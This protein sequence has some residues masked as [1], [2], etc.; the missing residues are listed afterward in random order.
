MDALRLPVLHVSTPI[1]DALAAMRE[2]GRSGVVAE[3]DNHDYW[4]VKAAAMIVA[5]NYGAQ[6]LGQV[7][8]RRPIR[9]LTLDRA[10]TYGLDLVHLQHTWMDYERLLDAE[11]VDYLCLAVVTESV[12]RGPGLGDVEERPARRRPRRRRRPKLVHGTFAT[13]VT[14]HED[15]TAELSSPG[16]CYCTGP[17]QHSFPPPGVAEGEPCPTGDG[18]KIVCE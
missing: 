7:E 8:E 6:I 2:A 13:I 18:H 10:A 5:R 4:L 14:R 17:R 12:P 16:D 3:D 1:P 11:G 15:L 9:P